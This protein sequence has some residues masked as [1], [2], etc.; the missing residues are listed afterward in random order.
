MGSSL[1]K[2]VFHV[3]FSTKDREPL[4]TNEFQCHL[5]RYIAGILKKE[6]AILLQIGG[7]PDHI[8]LVIR[9]KSVHSLASIVQKVKGCSSKWANS[10]C[11]LSR[12]FAWQEGYG[13]FSVSESQTDTLI[14]YVRNQKKHHRK[15]SFKTELKSLFDRHQIDYQE[16]FLWS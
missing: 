9:L 11:K 8:H 14:A 15:S 12:Q 10:E 1:T 16:K 5:Y 7:M 6:G 2:L 13:A 4:I 3:V